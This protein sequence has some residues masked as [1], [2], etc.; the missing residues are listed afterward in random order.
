MSQ[1]ANA[2]EGETE[3]PEGK[4]WVPSR[5]AHRRLYHTRRCPA[6]K[7]DRSS[8]VGRERSELDDEW[9]E[10]KRCA[11]ECDKSD[12]K[13]ECPLC[14]KERVLGNHLPECDGGGQ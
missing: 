6:V 4:V 8:F 13:R 9:S 11:G 3:P 10:C 7:D 14:G 5:A 1:S 2:A 12:P